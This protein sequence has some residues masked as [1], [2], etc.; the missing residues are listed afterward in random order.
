MDITSLDV[1]IEYVLD[2]CNLT[3]KPP[4]GC[5]I[6]DD[7]FWTGGYGFTEYADGHRSTMA[8]RAKTIVSATC[9]PR[10]VCEIIARYS[11]PVWQDW[12]RDV[13]MLENLVHIDGAGC[14]IVRELRKGRWPGRE[15]CYC[16]RGERKDWDFGVYVEHRDPVVYV[17]VDGATGVVETAYLLA[18]FLAEQGFAVK[19][20]APEE[21]VDETTYSL[22]VIRR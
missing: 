13:G 6:M 5:Q 3:V 17:D 4:D 8:S 12:E 9:M 16:V 18:Q 21:E 1:R 2:N 19:V 11:P 22:L 14:D 7:G 10:A 15:V 20:Y